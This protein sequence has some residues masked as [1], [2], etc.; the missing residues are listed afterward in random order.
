MT[1]A[2]AR[3]VA[4]GG[5]VAERAKPHVPLV[6]AGFRRYA[7]IIL[8]LVY[9]VNFLDRQIVTILAEPIK[10]E[11]G[12]SDTQLGV[13]T[14][15]AFGIIYVGLGLPLARLA[16]RFNRVWIIGGSMAV[17]SVFTMVCGR[18]MSFPTL[19]AARMGVAVGE[20]GCTPTAHALI[21]DY[22]PREKRASA[23]AFFS[24]GTPIGSVLGLALGG[25]LADTYGWRSAFLLAGLPGL[26]LAA[27]VFLTLREPRNSM[28]LAARREAAAAQMSF[29]ATVKYL[30][31]KPTF[32]FIAFA[33]SIKAF[34]G[35]GQAPFL[36]S[37][38]L[39]IHGEQL[40]ALAAPFHLKPLG[41]LGVVLGPAAGVL[42]GLSTLVGGAIG[43][44]FGAKDL[45]AYVSVPAVAALVSLP[46][47]C[48]AML[49][50]DVGLALL[51]LIPSSL[52]GSLW[53]GPVYAA[54]QGLVP[55]Q[56]RATAASIV[57]FIINMMGLGFGTLVV[58]AASDFFNIG[59]GLGKA[60][61]VRWALIS[62]ALL[63]LISALL[64]WLARR[65]IR[66]EMVS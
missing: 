58:G 34:I 19:V 61:G 15:F 27:V 51:L 60:E 29:T 36:I 30:A 43:D 54:A 8:L 63:G 10:N 48:A 2:A 55:P 52:L 32:W 47:F 20:A 45:R 7:L 56:M 16:D 53:Y 28:T 64:F 40:A 37:F 39:R 65:R 22:T 42:A 12:I 9:T 59:L 11:L 4:P 50:R 41:F 3:A 62:A 25:V 13:L 26:V 46:F 57:L 49:V 31:N 24:L 21:A 6:P 1:E 14:G 23:L 33:A 35:Y 38:F 5:E 17:W 66:E 18:A 44:R